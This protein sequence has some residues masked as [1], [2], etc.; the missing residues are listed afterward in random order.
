MPRPLPLALRENINFNQVIHARTVI[1][2]ARVQ[3]VPH[4]ARRAIA[5]D[6]L[7][8]P[9]DHISHVT[10]DFG[11]QDDQ[12]VPAALDSAIEQGSTPN[13]TMRSISCPDHHPPPGSPGDGGVAL[14]GCSSG[15]R[16]NGGDAGRLLRLPIGR[17]VVMGAQVRLTSRSAIVQGFWRHRTA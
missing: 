3:N 15:S 2:S 8:D 6:T 17:T 14:N 9:Y 10:P 4:I 1:V 12:D 13:S 5:I 16:F 7:G 11:F